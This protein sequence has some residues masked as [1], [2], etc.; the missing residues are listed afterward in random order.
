MIK[1]VLPS[2]EQNRITVYATGCEQ[3]IGRIGRISESVARGARPFQRYRMEIRLSQ[4]TPGEIPDTRYEEITFCVVAIQK[5]SSKARLY[6]GA[7]PA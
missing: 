5:N 6:V 3:K 7:R 2:L 4:A 1:Y